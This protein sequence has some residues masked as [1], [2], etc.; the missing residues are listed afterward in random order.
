MCLGIILVHPFPLRLKSWLWCS[1]A[2]VLSWFSLANFACISNWLSIRPPDVCSFCFS[3]FGLWG[4]VE[5]VSRE[6]S[7]DFGWID[8]RERK[9]EGTITAKYSN[10]YIG[11]TN[12]QNAVWVLKSIPLKNFLLNLQNQ[13]SSSS[14]EFL[15]FIFFVSHPI[16]ASFDAQKNAI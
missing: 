6:F 1:R 15:L 8:I 16:P 2:L 5:V 14:S 4:E 7:W 3:V 10:S 12:F 9:K 13:I 11:N